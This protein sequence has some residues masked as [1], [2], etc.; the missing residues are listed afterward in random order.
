MGLIKTNFILNHIIVKD[1]TLGTDNKLNIYYWSY[2]YM[3]NLN[4]IYS[5]FFF[6]VNKTLTII[7]NKLFTI[8]RIYKI[9]IFR[10]N[11]KQ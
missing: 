10:S 11:M 2:F 5:Y 7:K 9:K 6:K 8:Y 4:S 1:T 3:L